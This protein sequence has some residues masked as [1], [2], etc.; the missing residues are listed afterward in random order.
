MGYLINDDGEITHLYST[1][2]T[3]VS[4]M[5]QIFKPLHFCLPIL[6]KN[7]LYIFVLNSLRFNDYYCIMPINFQM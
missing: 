4:R 7:D 6:C 2:S 3:K 1:R 5:R